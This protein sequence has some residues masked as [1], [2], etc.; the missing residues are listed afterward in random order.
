MLVG[1]SAFHLA[2]VLVVDLALQLAVAALRRRAARM[3][4]LRGPLAYLNIT[5]LYWLRVVS[6]RR[7]LPVTTTDSMYTLM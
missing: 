4:L 2:L 6:T 5:G 7:L 3:Q 1:G